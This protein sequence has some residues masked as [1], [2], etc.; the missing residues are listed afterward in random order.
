MDAIRVDNLTK[1]YGEHVAVDGISFAVSQGEAFGILGPNGAGKTTT[2]EMIEGLR[3]PNVGTIEVLGR[4]VWPDPRAVQA[5]IG[6]QLQSTTLFDRLTARELLELFA[7]F[8]DRSDGVRRAQESLALVGLEAKAES[9][10][11]DMSGG[12]Q[13]RLAIALALVH[14]PDVVFL[15]EP[16]TGLD[17]QARRNLWDVIRAINDRAGKTVVLTTHYLEEAEELCD[18][19]AIMDESRVIALDTPEGLIAS[20][21]TDV[22]I[23]YRENG[24][25]KVAYAA[26]AQAAVLETL[27]AAKANGTTIENLTVRG[28]SLEDV[29]LNLTGREFRE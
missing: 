3:R 10:A 5:R 13:Q 11:E 17:P 8:Y 22:R 9:Y 25:D 15:D 12:Q 20:L 7:R 23:S 21:G 6:V 4:P 24:V 14:D 27:T 18:R 28:P 2:L 29:F 1:R 16:T 19:V 26:D